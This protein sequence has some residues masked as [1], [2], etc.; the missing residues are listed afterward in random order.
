MVDKKYVIKKKV[1][2]N[3]EVEKMKIEILLKNIRKERGLS[4]EKLAKMTGISSSHL[5]YIENN[6]KEPSLSVMVRIAQ[7]LSVN[8]TELYKIK[9]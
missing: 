5:N 2:N 3:V 4:L 9:N 6:E 8:I 7:A 1:H